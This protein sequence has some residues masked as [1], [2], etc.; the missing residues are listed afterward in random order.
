MTMRFPK[1]VLAMCFVGTAAIAIAFLRSS[2]APRIIAS[3]EFHNVAHRGSGTAELRE[4]PNGERSLKLFNFYTANKPDVVVYLISESDAFD[5]QTVK[6]AEFL[7]LGDLKQS[8]GTQEYS[9]PPNIDITKFRAVTIWSRRYEVNFTTA[10]L[11][12]R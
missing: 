1:T 6:L 7:L 8:E 12:R 11:I 4:Y 5:N 3:G 10:P 9:I 2:A